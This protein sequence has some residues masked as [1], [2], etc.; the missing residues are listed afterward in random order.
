VP[1]ERSFTFRIPADPRTLD[2]TRAGSV[3][4]GY[5]ISNLVECLVTV[6]STMHPVPALAESWTVSADQRVYVFKLRPGVKWSDGVALR[7]QDFVYAWKRLLS[8]ATGSPYGSLLHD[9]DGADLYS[10]GKLTDFQS[11]GV[12]AVDE[13]TLKVKLSHP[14]AHWLLL[15]AHWPTAPLR[16]DVVAKFGEGWA[17]P[18]TVVTLGPFTL[19]SHD[20]DQKLVLQANP[21]YYG[22][23]GGLDSVTALVI[24]DVSAAASLFEAGRLDAV[25][26]VPTTERARWAKRP[27]YRSFPALRTAYLGFS[28]RK[29]PASVGA[30]RR[31]I[32]M[33]LDRTRIAALAG[34]SV[35]GT[36]YVPPPLAGFGEV[37]LPFD[38]ARARQELRISGYDASRPLQ[39]LIPDTDPA[40]TI[41]RIIQ[42]QLKS[43]L[44]L[45]ITLA[46]LDL[47]SYY[48]NVGLHEYPLFWGTWTADYP[49]PDTFLS[50][51]SSSGG[52][53]N[54]TDWSDADYDRIVD[55]GRGI[56]DRAAL[57]ANAFEAERRLQE[58]ATVIIPL[59][60]DSTTTLI[61][62]SVRGFVVNP[63]ATFHLS[64]VSLR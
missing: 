35:P 10:R 21:L 44:G 3:V 24:P 7:A 29:Y 56:T 26:G 45:E 11:V 43:Q 19:Q 2:W 25:I 39:L 37:G 40:A 59:F 6:D 50:V 57:A 27:E 4:E 48:R 55:T 36:S 31:A 32:A 22:K 61:K 17:R 12:A 14:T 1:R 28:V 54:A 53:F 51:F 13:S 34:S 38:P 62:P 33:A 46:P 42:E 47:N 60:Y 15:A 23:K 63:M 30:L 52:D 18:G 5:I 9:I 16:E 58:K 8:P 41:A 49:D 20:V 64:E